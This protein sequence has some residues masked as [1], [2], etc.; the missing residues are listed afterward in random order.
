MVLSVILSLLLTWYAFRFFFKKEKE[1]VLAL[2]RA[3][4]DIF[5][6]M[7]QSGSM[8][9]DKMDP[10]PSDPEGI[11]IKAA[12]YFVDYLQYFS[13]PKS[14][15][16]ISVINFGTDTPE[17]FQLPLTEINSPDKIGEVKSKLQEYS[18]GYTNFYQGLRKVEEFYRKG[19]IPKETRQPVVIIFTDGEP[20]DERRL[21]REQYFNEINEF[22]EKNLRNIRIEGAVRP[23]NFEFFI[24]ALD[25]KGQYWHRDK[26]KWEKLAP[27][28]TFMLKQADEEELET[29]YAKIIE[30]LF[31]TQPGEW[32]DLEMGSEKKIL[33]PPYIE[34]VVISVKKERKV[35]DQKL[36]II[37]PKGEILKEGGRLRSSSGPGMNLY[38]VVEPV[39]GEWT[40]KL[41]PSGKVR[42]KQDFLPTKLQVKRP[43][44]IHPLGEPIEIVSSFSKSDG[45][46]V[47]PLPRYPLSFSLHV[48]DSD[49]NTF[50]PKLLEDKEIEGL[51]RTTEKIP[52]RKEGMYEIVIEVN[53]GAFLKTGNFTLSK[54]TIPIE[55]K[56]IVYFKTI[57]PSIKKNHSIYQPILFWKQNPVRVDGKLYQEGKEVLAR[58]LA[59]KDLDNIVLA[60][61][62]REPGKGMSNVAFLQYNEKSNMFEGILHPTERLWP[63]SYKLT[64]KIETLRPD[65]SKYIRQDENEFNVIFGFG[66]IGWVILF[67]LI[68]YILVQIFLRTLRGP[69]RGEIS[70]GTSSKKPRDILFYNKCRVV[71]RKKKFVLPWINTIRHDADKNL[72]VICP[73]FYV[74]GDKH[75]MKDGRVEPAVTIFYRKFLIIP[76]WT[77]LYRGKGSTTINGFTVRWTH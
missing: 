15:H 45:T 48:K 68:F 42:V 5:L 41:S 13:D 50:Q 22:I 69:L 29:I 71:S 51:Y 70:I 11:R 34:K 12:H 54:N 39:P 2:P 55:V 66:I 14:N 36:E 8:K 73:T 38:V 53:V 44:S 23:I 30:T 18:L 26:D 59:Y 9:G 74:I 64:T 33:I 72:N 61:I 65:G 52:T 57:Q 6:V 62:E 43:V 76:W 17:P 28:G 77:K 4:F 31:S 35:K 37:D 27:R 21:S 60:Q 63:G 19:K 47:I 40:L 7:D 24:I 16:R 49:G 75:K 46:P 3:Q 56:P 67:I 25:A 32:F 20:K 58:N 10:I 1:E